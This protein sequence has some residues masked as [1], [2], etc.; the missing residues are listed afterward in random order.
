MATVDPNLFSSVLD[1]SEGLIHGLNKGLL[2]ELGQKS[3]SETV[4]DC[5]PIRRIVVTLW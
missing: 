3:P 2:L 5:I 4:I 1:F